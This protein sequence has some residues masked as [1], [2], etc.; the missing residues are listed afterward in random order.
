MVCHSRLSRRDRK[1]APVGWA[2]VSL[3]FLIAAVA[4]PAP[5]AA[6]AP[7]TIS[8]VAG[9]GVWGNSGDG[10]PATAARIQEIYGI[11][12]DKD[13]SLYL[14]GLASKTV[15]KVTASDGLI[16]TVAGTGEGYGSTG[17]GG[18]ATAARLGGPIHLAVDADYNLYISEY[19]YYKIRKVTGA[20]GLIETV[21]G[22]GI[23]NYNGDNIPAAT[24]PNPR[25][26]GHRC[27]PERGLL[28]RGEQRPTDSEG[29]SGDWPD[30]DRGRD[31][32]QR[33]QRRRRAGDVRAVHGPE[34]R[35][36]RLGR[37]PLHSG[38]SRVPSPDGRRRDADHH[39]GSRDGNLRIQRRQGSGDPGA[40]E[41]AVWPRGGCGRGH[42]HRRH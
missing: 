10:G 6:Q 30:F 9:T 16:S 13:G 28:L 26:V 27:E 34:G 1:P 3:V 21:V 8:T 32:R 37:Q 7:G 22:T 15:R 41:L 25:P 33:G 18:L 19:L 29:H 36:T 5:A 2:A 39:D 12:V 17:D 4:L 23:P 40:I 11:A 38:L 24:R 35:R 20:S 14:T 42:L 31:W